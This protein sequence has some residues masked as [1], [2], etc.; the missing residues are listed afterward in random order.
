[1]RID[2]NA[3][4]IAASRPTG[5]QR[6]ASAFV[7]GL[8]H[9]AE[10]EVTLSVP[11]GAGACAAAKLGGG[12]TVSE[13]VLAGPAWELTELPLHRGR[14]GV[15]SLDPANAGPPV[16]PGP[17]VL[18]LH[19]VLPLTH[20]SSYAPAFRVWF[21]SV[22][23]RAARASTRI[24]T[25][26]EW[27]RG[28]A[29]RVLGLDPSRVTVISQGT[30]PFDTTPD[31]AAVDRTLAGLGLTR[32]YAL[33]LG[34]GDARKN[35]AFLQDVFRLWRERDPDAPHLVMVG[36]ANRWVHAAP[37]RGGGNGVH[38]TGFVSD[39]E[40]RALYAGADI[41]CFPSSAEGFGRPPLEA[42]ACGTPAVVSD[43]GCAREVLGDAACIVPLD[44]EAWVD[45]LSGI[46]GEGE[47][48]RR[49]RVRKGRERAALYDWDRGVEDLLALCRD[50]LEDPGP[51]SPA[52]PS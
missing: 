2:V 27:S 38:R 25:F 41:F 19:D 22:V 42:M 17:R 30:L 48:A 8:V 49:R 51:G 9:H 6:V 47:D 15:V 39:D 50:A 34:G 43:Y 7:R 44:P 16:S 18:L 40:L 45:A 12:A 31:R 52:E 13:G 11:R 37:P 33:A 35:P 28:E 23:A 14:E 1:M 29:V 46:V 21:R 36:S 24:A 32:G 10:A 26:T 3:R 5:V 4:F 20:P